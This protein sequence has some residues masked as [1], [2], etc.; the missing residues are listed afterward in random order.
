MRRG[1]WTVV[2]NGEIYNYREL[3]A[4][5]I[6]QHSAEF[7]TEGDCEVLAAAFHQWGPAALPRLR[8][9]FGCALWDRKTRTLHAA[10]DRFGIKPLCHLLTAEGLYLASEKKALLPLDQIR[11]RRTDGVLDIDNENRCH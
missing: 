11:A 9:M 3:R 6:E 1:R 10:R 8:G 4:E 7:A 5:L 2:L